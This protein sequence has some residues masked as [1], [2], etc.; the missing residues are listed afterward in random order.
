MIEKK[1]KK[2]VR[3][4]RERMKPGRSYGLAYTSRSANDQYQFSKLHR[5]DSSRKGSCPRL[6]FSFL[7]YSSTISLL[8]L[9]KSFCRLL[10]RGQSHRFRPLPTKLT[11]KIDFFSSLLFTFHFETR[12]VF[13]TVL[14]LVRVHWIAYRPTTC[15]VKTT[16]FFCHFQP[17]FYYSLVLCCYHYRP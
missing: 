2:Y 3:S 9:Q 8:C 12:R 13:F 4:T 17:F 16:I 11:H 14:T 10:L 5:F 1:I 6:Y 7:P 15:E